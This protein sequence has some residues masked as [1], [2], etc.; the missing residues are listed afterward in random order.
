M[1]FVCY[2]VECPISKAKSRKAWMDNDLRAGITH[3]LALAKQ[4]LKLA[5]K[6]NDGLIQCV[7]RDILKEIT[8]PALIGDYKVEI[9]DAAGQF[10]ATFMTGSEQIV[11]VL[12]T[13]AKVNSWLLSMIVAYKKGEVQSHL[14]AAEFAAKGE[15]ALEKAVAALG[16]SE[17]LSKSVAEMQPAVISA[18]DDVENKVT[19]VTV[20]ILT[21]TKTSSA[22]MLSSTL[23][24]H[25][26]SFNT[27]LNLGSSMPSLCGLLLG[28]MGWNNKVHIFQIVLTKDEAL[29]TVLNSAKVQAARDGA[30]LYPCGIMVKGSE[31][32]WS[33]RIHEVFHMFSH[34][35]TPLIICVDYTTNI[36]GDVC[37]WQ[38]DMSIDVEVNEPNPVAVSWTT[39]PHDSKRRARYNICWLD[40]W[41]VGHIEHATM[42]I[43]EAV[44]HHV[45]QSSAARTTYQQPHVNIVK[46]RMVD[47]PADG[48]CG[49]HALLAS[50]NLEKYEAVPRSAA[51]YPLSHEMQ[52]QEVTAANEL[53]S[54]VCA[55]ALHQCGDD[56]REHI[57]RVQGNP[58][59]EPTD[60]EWISMATGLSIRCTCDAQARNGCF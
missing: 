49:W 43:C 26:G 57:V 60:L 46:Y 38:L 9:A 20:D 25:K 47:I 14:R 41:Q 21:V 51:G 40:D 30:G 3:T 4:Q 16:V 56:F 13:L 22:P 5:E 17:D 55:D 52:H 44:V 53:H 35:D 31:E 54:K 48:K 18:T 37:A 12:P 11:K 45:V 10:K 2:H 50:M 1:C 36:G 34:C 29:E 27:F 33:Q 23:C 8:F 42:R 6:L 15:V 7:E 32:T 24:V 19:D 39:Q 59:F 28:K 58:S